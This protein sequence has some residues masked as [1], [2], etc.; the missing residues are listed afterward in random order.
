MFVYP[1]FKSTSHF[2]CVPRDTGEIRLSRFGGFRGC[3]FSGNCYMQSCVLFTNPHTHYG[4]AKISR[5]LQLYVSFTEYR[6]FYRAFLQKR[7]IIVR[8]LLIE[9]TP[10]LEGKSMKKRIASY[11]F[12]WKSSDGAFTHVSCKLA[13]SLDFQNILKIST[14]AGFSEIPE[15]RHHRWIFRNSWASSD[16]AFLRV[17]CKVAPSLDFQKILKIRLLTNPHRRKEMTSFEGNGLRII[18]LFWGK[19]PILIGHF[20]QT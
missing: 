2:K 16:G 6:L 5:L 18:R 15:N 14:V 1:H 8:S 3:I 7:R 17:S 4:V 19:W 20:P 11:S 10:Y 13:P 12:H 9:A